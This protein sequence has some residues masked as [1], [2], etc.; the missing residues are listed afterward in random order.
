MTLRLSSF[1]VIALTLVL[2]IESF[3][4]VPSIG[5]PTTSASWTGTVVHQSSSSASEESTEDGSPKKTVFQVWQEKSDQVQERRLSLE[6]AGL[7]D[8]GQQEKALRLQLRE[9]I[10]EMR[11]SLLEQTQD[12]G[13][14]D[15]VN[16]NFIDT[17]QLI[18]KDLR[19]VR[20][21]EAE[22]I[23]ANKKKVSD[24]WDEMSQQL[25]PLLMQFQG[26]DTT[27]DEMKAT[28]GQQVPGF[29]ELFKVIDQASS[30]SK[31]VYENSQFQ[32]EI[33]KSMDSFRS[34]MK[35]QLEDLHGNIRFHIRI[36]EDEKDKLVNE[37]VRIVKR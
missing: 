13:V 1:L 24:V 21:K 32:K 9:S 23:A 2:P 31:V 10:E 16:Q 15:A 28:M 11:E 7:K 5:T 36:S 3:S 18:I 22:K 20:D 12:F 30:S 27:W 17:R 25:S 33:K 4:L 6:Q 26:S 8:L 14:R 35:D 37:G 19:T 34:D 29:D